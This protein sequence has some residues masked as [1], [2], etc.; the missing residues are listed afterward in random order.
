MT[1][2][3]RKTV[4]YRLAQTAKAHRAR[5]SSHLSRIGLHP[6]QE[7]VMKV[8]ADQDGQTMSQLAAILGVQPPTVTKMVSRL[9]AQ[10]FVNRQASDSDGRLARVYLTDLG[11]ER[12]AEVDRAWKRLEKE[13]LTGLDE[14][15]RK[16]L[17]RLLRTIERNLAAANG[18]DLDAEDE[19]EE[20]EVIGD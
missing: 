8:L 2:N 3:Y 1:F 5:S 7:T 12:I 19:A 9:S 4:T 10:G 6:G 15:D 16:R 18:I 13:A 11:R 17:R 14:K 20:A